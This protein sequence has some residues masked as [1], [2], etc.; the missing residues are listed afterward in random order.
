MSIV[1]PS[2]RP[3]VY[4]KAPWKP[5]PTRAMGSWH[6]VQDLEMAGGGV[7]GEVAY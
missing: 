2:Q 7:A 3:S 5:P 6:S 4:H 1:H